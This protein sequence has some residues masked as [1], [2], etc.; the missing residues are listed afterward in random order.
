[1][2]RNF[3][4]TCQLRQKFTLFC[5]VPLL[6][7][8]VDANA[9]ELFSDAV[10]PVTVQEVTA[11]TPLVVPYITWGGEAAL[12]HANGG[13]TTRP[14]TIM[15][16]LGMNLKLVAGDNFQQQVRDYLTG[17][18]PFLRGTFRMIAQA[19][20]AVGKDARTKPVIFGQ[21]DLVGRGPFCWTFEY[22]ENFRPQ[23]QKD[24][25][26]KGWTARRNAL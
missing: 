11:I 10:G 4:L 18:S 3:R 23:R 6:L 24:R 12:F 26:P 9:Q 7:L 15:A 25:Y 2:K 14:G 8:A 1:M 19:S 5:L 22:P 16:N 13:L 20:E 17:K 21:L